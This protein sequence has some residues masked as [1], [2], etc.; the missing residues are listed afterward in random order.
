MKLKSAD[1]ILRER[2]AVLEQR[3]EARRFYLEGLQQLIEKK[4]LEITNL[5]AQE[6]QTQ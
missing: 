6:G 2:I 3:Q 4:E 5:K 1:R